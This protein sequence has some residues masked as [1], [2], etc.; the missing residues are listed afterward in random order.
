MTPSKPVGEAA[1]HPE[2]PSLRPSGSSRPRLLHPPPRSA[3]HLKKEL[4]KHERE[5][6]GWGVASENEIASDVLSGGSEICARKISC[7][8]RSRWP[9][10]RC[11]E[12]R[13]VRA[14]VNVHLFM[15]GKKKKI[16]QVWVNLSRCSFQAIQ[17]VYISLRTDAP[18]ET[19][20]HFL[21]RRSSPT[22]GKVWGMRTIAVEGRVMFQH[23][24][25]PL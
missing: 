11:G 16:E 6:E 21:P 12:I 14:F 7:L 24:C 5:A 17:A 10:G 18:V 13:G 3:S 25:C 2:Q 15:R 8:W 19:R 20:I 22:R 4:R 23:N 1:K 9:G